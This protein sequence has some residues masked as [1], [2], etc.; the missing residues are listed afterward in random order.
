MLEAWRAWGP[1]ALRRFRGM[2][3]FAIHDER[4]G[5]PHPGPRPAR[6]Q[7][8]VRHAPRRR[9]PVRLRA[10][11]DRRGR[12][13]RAH[14]RPGRHGRLDA[15]LLAAPG[16]RRRARAC[17]SS[18]PAPG[19]STTGTARSSSGRYWDTA[20]GGRA[21]RRRPAGRPRGAVV[22]AS[23]EAHL[24]ADVP[25]A[26][27]LS[28]GL[29]SSIVTALAHRS[30][31]SIEA[32]TIA[33]RAEDQRLEAMPDDARYARTHGRRTSASGCTR[34]RSSPDVVDL[35][36]RMVDILDEP[37]GD[38]AAINT[39]LMC[40]AARDAGV[41]V[42]LSGMGA[43]ELFGGYRKHLACSG[44]A[45][46]A[47]AASR[48]RRGRRPAVRAGCPVAVGGR[49]LR[50]V[51]WAQ[52][53]LTFAE[54]AEEEAFRRSYTLYDRDELA[55]LLDPACAGHVDTVVDRHRDGLRRQ[56]P[57]R[58]REPHVPG[59]HPDVHAG[60]QPD[61]HRPGQHGRVD[62]GARAVRRPGRLRG[63]VLAARHG[64]D[65]GRSR[66]RPSRTPR[67]AGC[68]TRS[69]TGP[70]RRSARRCARG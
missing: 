2:F 20:D 58:P 8:A 59:R 40:E 25:V 1:T 38:P 53:F 15:L 64:E 21:G 66:R 33:F 9:R 67:G 12:R 47:D 65:P 70:R 6:H 11:G 44:R 49:G 5:E 4:T 54:L 22:A 23:V 31:P 32:Y 37:I 68:P 19:P 7:A 17:T 46:P 41:K 69:S 30:D 29:D 62:R 57:R 52:R 16:G 28:G 48:P 56:R 39:L 63:R 60:P 50:T 42:L 34:S 61:L 24:V 55:G 27:F 35:L 13:P 3:A 51:R 45:L 10:E 36:P 26:S 43:D 18:P 14:R